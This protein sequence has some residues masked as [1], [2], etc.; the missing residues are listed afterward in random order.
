M[1]AGIA[2]KLELLGPDGRADLLVRF[3]LY[4]TD[5]DNR[6]AALTVNEVELLVAMA[7]DTGR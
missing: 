7:D 6:R 2:R 4:V 3:H 1:N 5:G